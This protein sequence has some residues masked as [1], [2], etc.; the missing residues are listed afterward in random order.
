VWFDALTNYLSG[1]HGLDPEHP[2]RDFWPA[3]AHIIGKDIIRFHCIYWPAMLLSAGR[4]W[5]GVHCVVVLAFGNRTENCLAATSLTHALSLSLVSFF[6]V[7]FLV[8]DSTIH[9]ASRIIQIIWYG[10]MSGVPLPKA[11]FSHGFIA[12]A[13]GRKMSKSFGNVIDPHDIL[14]RWEYAIENMWG[15]DVFFFFLILKKRI[16]SQLLYL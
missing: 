9:H 10:M 7:L 14:D 13:D 6:F 2:N 3:D 11:I 5:W 1:V 12:A 4:G 16:F 8:C 15:G